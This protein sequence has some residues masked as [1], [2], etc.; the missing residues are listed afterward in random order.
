MT[1]TIK[2]KVPI[3]EQ[4]YSKHRVPRVTTNL[5]SATFS[6]I[7]N[8]ESNDDLISLTGDRKLK[9]N[10]GYP[11]VHYTN[12]V[13]VVNGIPKAPKVEDSTSTFKKTNESRYQIK[14]ESSFPLNRLHSNIKRESD[15]VKIDESYNVSSKFSDHSQ[16]L[17]A[18]KQYKIEE[19]RVQ[20]NTNSNQETEKSKSNISSF[21]DDLYIEN[22]VR[23]PSIQSEHSNAALET[24]QDFNL[25]NVLNR[26]SE[27]AMAQSGET[28]MSKSFRS[29]NKEPKN[30]K[31]QSPISDLKSNKKSDQF[32]TFRN[33][34]NTNDKSQK[35]SSPN[36]SKINSNRNIS[37]TSRSKRSK[38]D[39]EQEIMKEVKRREKV[40]QKQQ[41][42][43]KL[44]ELQKLEK[45]LQQKEKNKQK[46]KWAVK[47]IQ[48]WVK[49]HI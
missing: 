6:D 13:N 29:A 25:N 33:N 19:Q 23:E 32:M 37:Q 20:T 30:A 5:E 46:K 35:N 10:V 3:E 34:N 47:I 49:G 27:E 26:I 38:Y 45:I 17:M 7:V 43:Q 14:P 44:K 8:Y 16:A 11:G 4:K 48:K 12:H 1:S 42:E 36:D 39:E 9:K 24:K 40:K 41:Y 31:H 28:L 15:M 21:K 18:Q 22:K 2:P